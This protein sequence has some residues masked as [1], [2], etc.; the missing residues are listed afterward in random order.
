MNRT[1]S[2]CK[3]PQDIDE[4]AP[5]SAAKPDGRRNTVCRSCMAQYGKQWHQDNRSAVLLRV[6]KQKKE[7]RAENMEYI[8]AYLLE[9]PCVDCGETDFA[10]LDFD[11]VRGKKR[12]GVFTMARDG[13]K[14]DTIKT[15]IAKCDVRCANDHRRRHSKIGKW[16]KVDSLVFGTSAERRAGSSPAF[17]AI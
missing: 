2:T 13:C 4:F 6:A 14:L 3:E 7:H 8:A 17:P 12:G 10:V 5:K 11:H 15:E 1:C 9:H 16:R